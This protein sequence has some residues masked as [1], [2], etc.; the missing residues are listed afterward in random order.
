MKDLTQ[1][2]I[3]RIILEMAAP[4]AAGMVFQTLYL[5]VDLY[6]VAGLGDAS[7]AGVGAAG[8]IMFLVMAL[9]QVLGVGAVALISQAVGRKDRDEANLVFNQSIALSAICAIATLIAGYSVGTSYVAS[10]AADEATRVEG[11]TFLRY[12]L[13]GLSLQFAMIAM[14]SAL[15]GTGIVKPGMVVQILTVLLNTILAPIFIAGWLTGMPLGVAGAGLASSVSVA[16]GIGML[17]FYFIK[18]ER[19]VGFNRALWAPR[20]HVWRRMLDVG[21]PAGGEFALMFVYMAVVYLVIADFGAASQAGF[22]I[23]GRVMQS[24]FLPAMAIAFA[25]GPIAGQNFGARRPDRVRETLN[26]ALILNAAV[27]IVVTAFLQWRSG[28]LIRVFTDEAD[29]I[30]IGSDFLRIISWNFLAQ[31]IIFTCSGIFQG[32]GNT[33]PALLSSFTRIALFTPLALLAARRDGF[34]IEDIWHLSVLTVLIQAV[35][36]YMLLQRQFRTRLA[37]LED[38]EAPAG[39]VPATGQATPAVQSPAAD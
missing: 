26:K 37:T 38:A 39:A 33:K 12:F 6:F 18:L 19:Y 4:I 36:S 9:T 35:L 1:G 13:P 2:S 11:V 28:L 5:L 7:V 34:Q 24:I 10:I 8:T 31:G 23:G 3:T 17:W 22:G 25:A 27:M 14:G 21:L 32:L 29:V 20:L 15:R 16:A 30:A